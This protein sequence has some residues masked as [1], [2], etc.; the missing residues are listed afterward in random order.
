MEHDYTVDIKSLCCSAPVLRLTQE[1][2]NFI[3]GK[4]ALVIS[5]KSSMLNDIPAYCRVTKHQLVKQEEKDG[6]FY[7][8]I[9]IS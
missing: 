5:D 3:V 7:F 2:K 6:L 9:K 4:V 1:F 8:W